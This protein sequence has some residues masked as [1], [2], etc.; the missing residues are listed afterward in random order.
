[1]GLLFFSYEK[2]DES[3]DKFSEPILVFQPVQKINVYR[4]C[5]PIHHYDAQY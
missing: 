4:M 2:F 5:I 3:I 1:M